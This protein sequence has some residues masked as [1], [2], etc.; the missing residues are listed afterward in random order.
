MLIL[1]CYHCGRTFAPDEGLLPGDDC[2]GDDC[3]GDDTDTPDQRHELMAQRDALLEALKDV[4][5]DLFMQISNRH[6]AKA[7]SEYPSI[8]RAK[9]AITKTEGSAA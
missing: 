6:G 3:P 8:V 9:A 1:F 7:A 2:P 4:R 5:G